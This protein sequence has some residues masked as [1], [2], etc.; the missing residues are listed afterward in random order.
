MVLLSALLL[1]P[2]CTACYGV[3]RFM[4]CLAV[5][6]L[7]TAELILIIHSKSA[8]KSISNYLV[9]NDRGGKHKS[10]EPVTGWPY[11]VHVGL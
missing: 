2:A 4:L 6:A 7:S 11:F 10:L 8:V 1:T 9:I 3:S 5:F